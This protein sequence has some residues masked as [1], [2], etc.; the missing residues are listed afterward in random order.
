MPRYVLLLH[1]TPAD[2]AAMTPAE[3]KDLVARYSAW[4]QT[5]RQQGKVKDGIKLTDGGGRRL[6]RSSG[7]IVATDGPYSEAK[8]VIGGLF[9]IEA[10]DDAEAEA[11]TRNCPHLHSGERNWVELRRIDEM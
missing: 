9:V 5:M 6:A 1:E 4:S 8:E 11:L 7:G 2:Y 3:M 10:A